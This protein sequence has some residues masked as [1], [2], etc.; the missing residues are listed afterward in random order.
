M[1]RGD[2]RGHPERFRREREGLEQ[3]G[4]YYM[5]K[6]VSQR[7]T[8]LRQRLR[9]GKKAKTPELVPGSRDAWL[10]VL[11]GYSFPG[12]LNQVERAGL[13]GLSATLVY[14]DWAMPNHEL[15]QTVLDGV[16]QFMDLGDHAA[17]VV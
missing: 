2:C 15:E 4:T 10:G 14:N 1:T 12:S 11:G 9:R 5:K 13:G 17:E 8:S 16:R 3:I 6:G 7:V